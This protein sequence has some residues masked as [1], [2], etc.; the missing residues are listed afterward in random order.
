MK[1]TSALN[2]FKVRTQATMKCFLV[3]PL[4]QSNAVRLNHQPGLPH[5]SKIFADNLLLVSIWHRGAHN[6]RTMYSR[7]YPDPENG[8]GVIWIWIS[9]HRTQCQGLEGDAWVWCTHLDGIRNDSLSVRG[10][11]WRTPQCVS[12][13]WQARQ[14]FHLPQ[15]KGR[16]VQNTY[17]EKHSN[18]MHSTCLCS[19]QW[20][21]SQFHSFM[22]TKGFQIL[23]ESIFQ[24]GLRPAL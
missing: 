12:S 7:N 18:V 1:Y 8:F 24:G 20:T 6:R 23:P 17:Q 22:D 13:A 10:I 15:S 19:I 16:T 9:G 2:I 21:S 14:G 5:L 4:A 11:C 3:L